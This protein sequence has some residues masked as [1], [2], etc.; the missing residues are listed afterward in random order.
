ME[1]EL[2]ENEPPTI[3][4]GDASVAAPFTSKLANVIAIPNIIRQGDVPL[5]LLF[6][7]TKFL[8]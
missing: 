3:K 7:C 8:L 4:L 1:Q 5:L 6:R 2:D